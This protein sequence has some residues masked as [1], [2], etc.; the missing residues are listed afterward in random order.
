MSEEFEDEH[1]ESINVKPLDGLPSVVA[2]YIKDGL[3]F[4][5]DAVSFAWD[6]AAKRGVWSSNVP[7]TQPPDYYH[8]VPGQMVFVWNDQREEWD[9][10]A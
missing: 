10:Y 2:D 3:Y 8:Q 7:P 9:R 5:H 1:E 4:L 6:V